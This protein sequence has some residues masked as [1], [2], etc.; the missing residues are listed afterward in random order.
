MM[1]PPDWFNHDVSRET[2]DKLEA[3]QDLLIKWTGKINLIARST[4][5]EVSLRHIWD[6][7]QIYQETQGKWADL[8]AGGGLPGVVVAV[9][10]AGQGHRLAVT[11]IESDQRKS[12]F[13]RTC[14][15]ALDVPMAIIA[16]RI[17]Q[18]AP[19]NA[20]TVSARAL[21]PLT[22]L[23]EHSVRHMTPEGTAFFMK[24]GKW[25]SEI[26][27]AQQN[28]RFSYDATASKTNPDAAILRIRDI[29]RA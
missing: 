26:E 28:W 10:A 5:D 20:G 7:A 12:T 9:L 4:I 1:Q 8:G 18:A 22:D 3:Y 27:E 21:A 6:S 29:E 23:L 11:L 25:Q 14:A 16:Q 17:E 2:L 13:L 24:G 19:Q 15:R